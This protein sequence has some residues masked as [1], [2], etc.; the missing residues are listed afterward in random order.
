M[1]KLKKYP[2]INNVF[3]RDEKTHKLIDG[4]WKKPEFEYLQHTHWVATEKIDGTNIRVIWEP[5][6]HT[7]TIKGRTEKSQFPPGLLEAVAKHFPMEWMEEI[8]I[9]VVFFGEGYGAGIQSGGK[10]KP[11]K[12]FVLFDVMYGNGSWFNADDIQEFIETYFE[13]K[14][15]VTPAII[16][17]TL[18]EIIDFASKPFNSEYGDFL[19]EGVV[20][21]PA[22]ELRNQFGERVI[23][24]IKSKDFVS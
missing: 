19:A 12:D 4:E 3:K 9:P 18:N 21:R 13:G 11:K 5:T 23:V 10:Y 17:G 15:P 14:L 22:V 1:I 6:I 16:A 7:L 8:K 24:K 2:K 20:A